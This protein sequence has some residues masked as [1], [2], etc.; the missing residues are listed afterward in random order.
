MFTDLA[1]A[2]ADGADAISGIG[3]LTDREELF[4]PVAS[5]PTTWRVLDRV[6]PEQLPTVRAARAKARA[7]AWAAGAGPD[8][9]EELRLDFDA[10]ITIAHSEKQNAA[11]TWKKTFGFH[12]CCASW[13]VPTSRAE[14]RAEKP[15]LGCCGPGMLA[16]TPLLTTSPCSTRR[17]RRCPNRPGLGPETRRV[18]GCWPG[19]TRPA[20]PTR[21]LSRA[22]S[23]A[24]SLSFGFPMDARIQGIVDAIPED[25]WH[26]ALQTDGE[27]RDGAWVAE[28]T[29]MIDLSSWP[30]G[31][32]LILRKERPHPGAQ[33][34]FTDI[35]G[36]RVTALLT[37]T[38]AGVVPFQAAG[39]ELRHRQHARVEDRI[40]EARATGLRNLPCREF[41]ENQAWLETVLTAVD[42]ICW[43][44][45]ICFADAVELA[46]CEI[47]A[48]R[49][50]VL[51]VATRLT[52]SARQLRLRIDKTWRWA[53]QIAEGFDRLRAAFA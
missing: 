52:R 51:H 12:R 1:V 14:S 29:G 33:L 23:V 24:W 40:R 44:K 5:M 13:T 48:F 38:P 34:T 37:N 32:R 41:N 42:L 11:A 36:M 46:R 25:C 22:W 45:Q 20:P 47:A 15:S 19:R 8:L 10:T 6:G 30:D 17:W 43:T 4:G 18:R 31:S 26:P 16:R 9:G 35:D 28:A 2:V 39:L 21:S 50:R 27:F 49:Y 3:V 7:A 53:A